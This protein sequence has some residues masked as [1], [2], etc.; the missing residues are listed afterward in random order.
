MQYK[1]IKNGKSTLES[2]QDHTNN[3]SKMSL[4]Q[5]LLQPKNITKNDK[6]TL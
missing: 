2:K 5:L 6:N 1:I 4:Q 3:E